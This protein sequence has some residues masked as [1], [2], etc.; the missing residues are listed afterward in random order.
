M[1]TPSKTWAGLEQLEVNERPSIVWS[2]TAEAGD[3]KSWFALTSPEPIWVA[4][5]DAAG[6]NRVDKKLKVGR[7]IRISRFPFDPTKFKSANDVAKAATEIWN[8]F[9]EEYAIALKNARSIHWDREDMAY[10]LQRFSSWGDTN[11]APKEYEDLYAEYVGLIQ[12]ANLH[13]VN[14]GL[15]RGKKDKW[16][17]K[18]DP[19]KGKMVGHNTG[20]RIAEGMGKVPDHVDIELFHR[21]DAEQHCYITKFGKFPVPEERGMEYPNLTF[22]DMAMLAFPETTPDDW[23]GAYIA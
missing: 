2:S 23:Q 17:S 20:D 15:L 8:R 9:T 6:M 5:F 4:A 12:Q 16:V 13:G 1:A 14:L 7:D 10:K 22:L 19:G 21:F 18:F 3:G 11:A